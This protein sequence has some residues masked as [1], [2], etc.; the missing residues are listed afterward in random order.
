MCVIFLS[1]TF[2]S[3]NGN[4]NIEEVKVND[5]RVNGICGN[6]DGDI[7]NDWRTCLVSGTKYQKTPNTVKSLKK[8]S[9]RC[10]DGTHKA[11]NYRGGTKLD[12]IAIN[13]NFPPHWPGC[14]WVSP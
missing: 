14:P 8:I 2:V 12:G 5:N 6:M 11:Q 1:Q 10:N 3:Q 13:A 7:D 4:A 9:Q